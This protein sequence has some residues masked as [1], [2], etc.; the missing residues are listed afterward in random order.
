MPFLLFSFFCVINSGFLLPFWRDA[1][2]VGAAMYLHDFSTGGEI[3]DRPTHQSTVANPALSR[4]QIDEK[5]RDR[6]GPSE[7]RKT[8]NIVP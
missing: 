8:V 6:K 1:G 2:A 3:L 4:G 7:L 5:S